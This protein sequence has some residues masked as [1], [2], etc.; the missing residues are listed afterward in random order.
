MHS[1]DSDLIQPFMPQDSYVVTEY[2]KPVQLVLG[3]FAQTRAAANADPAVGPEDVK[4]ARR[5]LFDT[6][7]DTEQGDP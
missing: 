4:E 3:N 5:I 7:A 6:L 2:S 1:F